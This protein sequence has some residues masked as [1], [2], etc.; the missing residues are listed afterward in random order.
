MLSNPACPRRVRAG[1]LVGRSEEL[2]IIDSFLVESAVRGGVLVLTGEA[3]AGKTVLLEVA[4]E[5]ARDAGTQVL[6]GAGVDFEADVTYAGLHQVLLPLDGVF[7]LLDPGPRQAL[8]AALGFGSSPVPDPGDVSEAV[9]ALLRRAAADRPVL[10]ILDDVH[11]LDRASTAVL[12]FVSQRVSGTRCGL[13]VAS[14]AADGYFEHPGT[15][16]HEVHPLDDETATDLLRSRFPTLAPR[17]CARLVAEAQGNA[18]ALLELGRE[19]SG[20]HVAQGRASAVVAPARSLRTLFASRVG[21][22][23]APTR[24][25]LLRSALDTT[26]DPRILRSTGPGR[27]RSGDITPAEQAGLVHVDE[28]AGRVEFAHPLIRSVVVKQSTSSELRAAHQALAHLLAD[29]PEQ[30]AWHLAEATIEPDEQVAV[31][32]ADVGRRSMQRGDAVGAVAALLRSAELSPCGSDRSRRLA[33]AAYT[34]A[35][36][37]GELRSTPRLLAAAHEADPA[38]DKPLHAAAAASYMLLSGEGDVDTAHRL[39]V[40]ATD[41]LVSQDVTD[42]RVLDAVLGTLLMGCFFGGRAE[43]WDFFHKAV[44]ATAP[45]A[46]VSLCGSTLRDPVRAGAAVLGQLDRLIE[47][48]DHEV[49]P[50]RI[51]WL[52]TAGVFVDRMSGLRDALWRVVRDGRQG[53]AVASA[54][55]ALLLLGFDDFMT[56]AWDEAEDLLEEGLQLCEAHGYGLLTLPGRFVQ[57]LLAAGRGDFEAAGTLVDDITAWGRARGIQLA[58]VYAHRARTLIALGRGDHEEAYRHATAVTPPGVFAPHSPFALHVPLDLVEAAVRC[59][60][61]TEADAHVTAMRAA[62][63]AALSPR[64]ALLAAGAAAVAASGDMATALFE[65]ALAVP[66]AER[67]SFELARVR[68]A[69]G[70]H[71]RRC[72]AVSASRVQLD[73]ALDAFERMGARPWATRARNELRATGESRSR[74]RTAGPAGL[75]PREREVAELAASGLSNKQIGEKLRLSPRTVGAHLRH[76]FQKLGVVSRVALGAAL[77]PAF[78]ELAGGAGPRRK[79]GM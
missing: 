34:G 68:L 78:P 59:N 56:G 15:T 37:T 18:L 58:Q 79:R 38:H 14:R 75:T 74:A 62:G 28:N 26:G 50:G 45:D 32:L 42:E 77:G 7:G 22:L 53:G 6:R 30:R 12:D 2:A 39:L 51:V 13:V 44:E 67:W 9:L 63:V 47:E 73:A 21:E 66:G 31:L 69:Y 40:G 1:G 27:P 46:L 19:E 11:W 48:S 29:Q 17:V 49:D 23:P 55:N 10:V 25:L 20:L 60:R 43:L 71:L 24:H 16:G 54:V 4:A 57:A 52:A 41:A 76:V 61:R 36:V 65:E 3:G 8:S 33:E 64:L 35:Q 72:R 5:T 70:E